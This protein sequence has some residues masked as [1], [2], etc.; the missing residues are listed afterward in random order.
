MAQT[1][2]DTTIIDATT[3]F[4]AKVTFLV[5]LVDRAVTFSFQKSS[6]L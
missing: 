3:S 1:T 6:H 4:Q 2:T 5:E